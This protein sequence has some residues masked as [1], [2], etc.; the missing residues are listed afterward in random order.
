MPSPVKGLLDALETDRDDTA[1]WCALAD[2]LVDRDHPCLAALCRWRAWKTNLLDGGIMPRGWDGSDPNW[3]HHDYWWVVDLCT[4][5]LSD[6]PEGLARRLSLPIVDQPDASELEQPA[7][8]HMGFN[9]ITDTM[10]ACRDDFEVDLAQ[11]WLRWCAD[12]GLATV[13]FL[14]Q[15]V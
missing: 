2:Y 11:A 15:E 3:Q 8:H 9:R 1:A 6:L 10:W 12:V 5:D 13:I 7:L 14:T 4:R